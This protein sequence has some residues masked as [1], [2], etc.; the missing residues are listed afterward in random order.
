[1]ID[2]GFTYLGVLL[3]LAAA[4]VLFKQRV[5]WKALAYVP[6][7]VLL[8][9]LAALLNTVGLFG[10][11]DAV[12][13][14]GSEVRGALLPAM[15]LLFLLRC[16]LRQIVRL[17][18]KLL[19]TYV[20][21]TLSIVV[22]FVVA[23]LVLQAALDPGAYKALGALTGSWTGGS[24]NM[25]AVQDVVEAPQTLFGYAL[26]TDTIMYSVWLLVMFGSVGISDR[27]NR[28]TR[29]DT[30][31]LDRDLEAEGIGVDD[32]G[33]RTGLVQLMTLVG[34]SLFVSAM[35][36]QVGGLLPTFGDVVDQTTWTILIVSVLGLVAAT[37]PVGK[38]PGSE[39]VGQVMLYV[40]IAIIASGS[41]FSSIA[42][43]PLYLVFGAIVLV[44]HAVVVVAYAK[45]TRTELFSLAVAS[46]ANIGG[47]ASAPVVAGA[48][49]KRMVP[50]GVL[51]ALIGSFLGTF[52][53]LGTVQL[54]SV[55]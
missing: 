8:Y 53:G 39:D 24:A 21:A 25:V 6:G 3:G 34:F 23:Y 45:L 14:I 40:I 33:R 22:G 43:A 35:A 44:V 36:S 1:M 30:S 11:S 2:D 46:T 17:G 15:I 7:F 4:I 38:V 19:L 41:D 49:D 48:Y 9:I 5:Q 28:W 16:D 27:F 42:Q 31:Y 26:I 12:T 50:V 32:G 51:F 29:A 10:D 37:T 52:I 47:V 54:L 13:T 55:I 20:V 18:P